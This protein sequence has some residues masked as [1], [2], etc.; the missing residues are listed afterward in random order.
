MKNNILNIK[1]YNN[2]FIE[3]FT[4][5]NDIIKLI[6]NNFTYEITTYKKNQNTTK[7]CL[8]KFNKY[9]YLGLLPTLIDFL[10]THNIKYKVDDKLKINYKFET[11]RF[12]KFIEN[13][14]L[15]FKP[16][17]H[18][19]WA[20][21]KVIEDGSHTVFSSTSSGKSLI[22][23]MLTMFYLC[24]NTKKRVVIVVP[25]KG[26]VNQLYSDF[27]NYAYNNEKID[28]SQIFQKLH[29]DI[30]KSKIDLNKFAL[31][32]TWQSL[33]SFSKRQLKEYGMVI[34]DEAHEAGASGGGVI[35][36]NGK[37]ISG[38]KVSIELLENLTETDYRCG[39]T[40]SL[41]F[42][43]NLKNKTIE[44]LLGETIVAI[45][46]RE[47]IEEGYACEVN[48]RSYIL[49]YGHF[50]FL[51]LV[52]NKIEDQIVNGKMTKSF[53][54]KNKGKIKYNTELDILRNSK[55]RTE[56]VNKI[57]K[58]NNGNMILLYNSIDYG[59]KIVKELK[60]N[61]PDKDVYMINGTIKA[62]ERER[63][64]LLMNKKDNIIL[65]ATYKTCKQ[66]ISIN[67][68][69]HIIFLESVK[70]EIS[71]IQSIGRG[72]RLHESKDKVIIH[73]IVDKFTYPTPYGTN[74]NYV[75]NHYIKRQ[76]VYNHEH[77]NYP[78]QEIKINM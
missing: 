17:Y 47:M 32:T 61:F 71:V 5:S 9:L 39:L 60:K 26:L 49:N 29:S 50:D 59:N 33:Y 3:L 14:K 6:R 38:T 76:E 65:V 36:P 67:N 68:L 34:W 44:G 15:P 23:Y 66:G 56:F 20:V 57:V 78:N 11:K 64:R 54:E 16:R 28:V 70:S 1:S 2:V 25:N 77:Y 7:I 24:K 22:A 72:L 21:K 18:Q 30:P 19:A 53:S 41:Y 13:L 74:Y 46:A 73:D 27:N 58:N 75:Y 69:H 52:E 37:K 40:G 42:H 51:N 48:I 8:L 43:N 10:E 31:I 12:I 55:K 62:Q 35:G 4:L 45:T 63:I